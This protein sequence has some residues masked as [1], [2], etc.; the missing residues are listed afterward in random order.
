MYARRLWPVLA[1]PEA[2]AQMEEGCQA[3]KKNLGCFEGRREHLSENDILHAP[4][5]CISKLHHVNSVRVSLEFNPNLKETGRRVAA[6][7]G[8]WRRSFTATMKLAYDFPSISYLGH[9]LTLKHRWMMTT[10]VSLSDEDRIF[11]LHVFKW[12]QTP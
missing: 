5:G 8:F 2:F 12:L 11:S 1:L 4:L 10:L 9:L 7:F 3:V 6:W